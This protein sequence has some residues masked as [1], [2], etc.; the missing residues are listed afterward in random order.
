MIPLFEAHPRLAESLPRVEIAT[1]PTPVARLDRMAK[2]LGLEPGRLFL[3][4]DDLTHPE[5]G[6]NKVRKLEFL[7]GAARRA[8]AREVVTFGY[9]GS[10]HATATAIHA[11]RAGFG[12][13]SMLLDQRPALHSGRNLLWS[14]AAGADPRHFRRKSGLVLAT[15]AHLIA[16]RVA[17]GRAPFVIPAGGSS[18][19]G[20]V[21]IV[22]AAFELKAQIDAGELPSPDRI[23]VAIGSMGTAAGLAAGLGAAGVRAEI[24]GVQVAPDD[25]CDEA[26]TRSLA[27]RVS[28]MLRGLDPAFPAEFAPLRFVAGRVGEGYAA[29]TPEGEEARALARAEEGIGLEGTYTAK[30][31]GGLVADARAGTLAGRTVLFWNTFNSRRPALADAA[32]GERRPELE[33]ELLRRGFGAYLENLDDALAHPGVGEDSGEGDAEGDFDAG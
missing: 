7:L 1:L 6:G 28:A 10:N 12:V 18:P 14:L 27:S 4:R 3:K 13:R 24:H 9:A 17:T 30:A 19:L 8:G 26:R 16:R 23:Y 29:P 15:T 31:L 22:N 21:G 25:Y 32:E 5:Y 2:A 11:T 20:V 33:A